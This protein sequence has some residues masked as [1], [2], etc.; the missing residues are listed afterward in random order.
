MGTSAHFIRQVYLYGSRARCD[1]RPEND[2]DLAVVMPYIDW[3]EWH[4]RYQEEPDLSLSVPV[5]LE[6]YERDAGLELVGSGVERDG[7]LLYDVTVE[8]THP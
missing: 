7:I 4:K 5:H 2:I 1:H 6:W 3:F 8:I